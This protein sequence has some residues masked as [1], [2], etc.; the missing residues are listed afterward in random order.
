MKNVCAKR[1]NAI[2]FLNLRT[3]KLRAPC[4]DPSPDCVTKLPAA[5]C[6]SLTLFDSS[7]IDLVRDA[8][9]PPDAVLKDG[10][11]EPRGM[12]P[13]YDAIGQTIAD[14]EGRS[15]GFD[16]VALVILTDGLENASVEFKRDDVL[17]LLKENQ[18]RDGW[19][20]IYLGANQDAWAV[21]KQFGTVADNSMSFDA[22]KIGVAMDSV[23]R[24]TASYFTA[25]S[26]GVIRRASLVRSARRPRGESDDPDQRLNSIEDAHRVPAARHGRPS[27]VLFCPQTQQRP[28]SAR[29]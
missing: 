19:L 17:K 12:T 21:G 23:S 6:V 27:P 26:S 24:A 13:L 9:A 7:G 11:F 20:V 28:R 5:A 8:V 4:D 3:R 10:E 15:K 22:D 14:A 1:R 16:R 29:R 25:P 2:G 18:E